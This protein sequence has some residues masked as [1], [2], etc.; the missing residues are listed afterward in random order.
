MSQLNFGESGSLGFGSGMAICKIA[1]D[2]HAGMR[3]VI[4]KWTHDLKNSRTTLLRNMWTPQPYLYRANIGDRILEA[5]RRM[6]DPDHR[7]FLTPR[8]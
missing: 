8:E 6:A 4:R 2:G 3:Y 1:L 7:P 5:R